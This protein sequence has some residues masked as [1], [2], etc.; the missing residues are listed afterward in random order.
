M[1]YVDVVQERGKATNII[2]QKQH[3]SQSAIAA[4]SS[5]TYIPAKIRKENY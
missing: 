5:W 3:V 4:S 2:L 1:N